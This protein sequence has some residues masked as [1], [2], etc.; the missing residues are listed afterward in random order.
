MRS[1]RPAALTWITR[2][3]ERCYSD[4]PKKTA[5]SGRYGSFR[6][7]SLHV[8][9]DIV[10]DRMTFRLGER[11]LPKCSPRLARCKIALG[12]SVGPEEDATDAELPNPC[13]NQRPFL[14]PSTVPGNA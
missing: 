1:S 13:G 8:R 2:R 12:G 14:E 3:W 9:G 7:E 6:T 5:D 4:W 11:Q 10:L